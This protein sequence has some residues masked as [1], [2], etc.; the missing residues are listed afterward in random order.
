M[1]Y[2]EVVSWCLGL[3]YSGGVPF[4]PQDLRHAGRVVSS[5]VLG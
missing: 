1:G 5:Q 3:S 2:R 4:V